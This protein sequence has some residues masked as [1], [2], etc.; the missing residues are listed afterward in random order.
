MVVIIF[1]LLSSTIRL[2]GQCDAQVSISASSA[3]ICQGSSVTFLATPV[4]AGTSPLFQ[5]KV[6]GV[7]AGINN[8]V[9]ITSTLFNNDLI[10]VDLTP[11]PVDCPA[12]TTVTSNVITMTVNT[13]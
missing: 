13:E 1:I 7:N 11:D 3:V 12:S 9:F 4:N 6:N 8:S 10:S 5:W 2:R